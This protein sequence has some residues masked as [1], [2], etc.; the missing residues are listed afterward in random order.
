MQ[1][2]A[3]ILGVGISPVNLGQATERVEL[4]I[5]ENRREYVCVAAAHSIMDCRR[6]PEVRRAFNRAAMVTPDGMS[7]V[8]CLRLLGHA[9]VG[10]V[11]GPDLLL[12]LCGRSGGAT[13]RHLFY[14]GTEAL[15]RDLSDR[16]RQEFP[17]VEI[18]GA[19]A[20][21]FRQLTP[22]EDAEVIR[23]IGQSRADIVWVGIGSPKQE[24]WMAEH[25]G[26][27]EAPIMIGVGAAFDF[28]SGHKAQAPRWVR[29]AG[30]EWLF[31]L[32]QEPGRL[33]GR[34]ARYPLFMA[35]LAAQMLRILRFEIED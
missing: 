3:N 12:A 26:R 25:V 35:L 2:K 6:D 22:E 4:S 30:L 15:L 1:A 14:G 11:Y 24:R 23:T 20:P 7:L 28:V 34:Y 8:W 16:L 21:P 10:R 19:I 17:G 31:R 5:R 33:W 27:I 9:Q 32:L 13:R 29:G 18:V